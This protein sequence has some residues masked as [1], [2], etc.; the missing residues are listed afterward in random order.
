MTTPL[1]DRVVHY[2][3]STGWRAPEEKGEVGALWRHPTSEF[4][5]PVPFQLGADGIDLQVIVERL[6]RVEGRPAADIAAR[7]AEQATD[8][9]KL[10]AAN[11]SRIKDTIAFDAGVT[12]MRSYWTMLR[13]SA[14]TATGPRAFIR[15]YRKSGD[16]LVA[17]ARMAHT[18]RGSFVIPIL[19]PLSE[20]PPDEKAKREPP[21]QGMEM[22]AAPEPVERRVMRTFAESL[23]ALD[24]LVVQPEREPKPSMVPALVRAGVSHQ[25][26]RALHDVLTEETVSEFSASFEWAPVGEPPKGVSDVAI[27]AA[28]LPRVKAVVARLK[29]E[30][31]PR[32]E[33]QFVGPIRRVERDPDAETGSV[34]VQSYRN[35][36]PASIAVR[37]SSDVLDQAWEW[38]RAHKT[39]VVNSRVRRTSDGLMAETDDAVMPLMLDVTTD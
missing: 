36:H 16:E 21:L 25:F 5:L 32:S 4:I 9:V 31:T 14:T 30:R 38:A 24:K 29:D 37:V 28:A 8:V 39:L 1:H 22:T 23:A 6:S 17:S 20:P 12:L 7:L 15:H 34:T 10:R 26:V 18:R 27:P 33:E 13:S 3:A 2:L 35:G 11:D 19:L